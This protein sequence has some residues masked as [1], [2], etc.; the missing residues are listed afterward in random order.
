MCFLDFRAGV[1]YNGTTR[2]WKEVESR[3]LKM[4]A[5]VAIEIPRE[6]VHVVTGLSFAAGLA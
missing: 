5:T 4:S 6:I 1:G 2:I 3:R